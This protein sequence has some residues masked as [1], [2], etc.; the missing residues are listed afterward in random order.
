MCDRIANEK[1]FFLRNKNSQPERQK[2]S[3]YYIFQVTNNFNI[4]IYFNTAT[5]LY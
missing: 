3:I 4:A 5:F 1:I 2:C